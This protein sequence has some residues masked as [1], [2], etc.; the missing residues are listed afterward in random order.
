M[1]HPGTSSARA[2]E[3]AGKATI[4]GHMKQQGHEVCL[5]GR[6]MGVG[7]VEYAHAQQT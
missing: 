3:T 4:G 1:V 6:R 2:F 5:E 7:V